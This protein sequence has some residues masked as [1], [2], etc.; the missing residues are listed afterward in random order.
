MEEENKKEIDETVTREIN[1][2]ELYDGAVNNTVIIDPIT[3]NEVL[4]K[5]KH[6]GGKVLGIILLLLALLLLYF[7][8]NK[9]NLNNKKAT[10]KPNVTTT[11]TTTAPIIKKGTLVCTYSSESSSEKQ[12]ATYT[13]NY[14]NDMV[15][16]SE[17]SYV[18]NLLAE[19]SE[20]YNDLQKQYET[21][22]INNASIAGVTFTKDDKSFDFNLKVKY[23]EADF[24]K[25]TMSDGQMILYAMP[26][27]NDTLTSVQETY[28]NKGY[29]CTSKTLSG[30]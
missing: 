20:I 21:F 30:E 23:K 4:L 11:T 10:V 17:F 8:T 24:S 28:T 6:N 1:L 29:S 7:V 13:V 14:E 16:D 19:T 18:V 27:S 3:K 9:M 15:I 25:Y 12:S 22:F 2:D 26:T 5:T